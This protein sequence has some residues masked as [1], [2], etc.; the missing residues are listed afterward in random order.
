[1]LSSPFLIITTAYWSDKLKYQITSEQRQEFSKWFL[2]AN[3]KGRYSR[4]ST[5]T[6]LDQDLA[7]I[8][9]GGEILSLLQRLTQQVGRLDFTP[10]ELVGRTSRSGAFKTMFLAFRQDNARDWATSLEISPKHN[11][12]SDAIEYHHIFPKAY[13]KR[14]RRDI[15]RYAVDDIANLAF[16]G[17]KTNKLISAK[18][19]STYRTFFNSS[20]LEDQQIFFEQGL[21]TAKSFELFVSS[22]RAYIAARINKFLGVD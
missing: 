12:K 10:E 15:D 14:E 11:G 16:I 7:V 21:D 9:D 4:G 3:A 13:L 8:R 22:R 20:D 1:L 5:E 18:S 6:L 19:P 2:L 17:S